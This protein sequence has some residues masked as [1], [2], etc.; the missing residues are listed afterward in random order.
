MLEWMHDE[1][2]TNN[3]Q[4]KFMNITLTDCEAFIRSSWEDKD[5]LHMAAADDNDIYMGTV[6]LKNIDP[7]AKT[8]EFAIA[9]RRCALGTGISAYAMQEIL[10]HGLEVLGLEQIYW[11][12]SLENTRAVRFYD[13]HRYPRVAPAMLK[14]P[15]ASP[16][17]ALP[18][19]I[20]YAVTQ[21]QFND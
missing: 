3:L 18:N 20:F 19:M 16:V 15:A 17:C 5:N 12:V 14:L 1:D 10:R 4:A 8:A 6:S 2:L 7:T 13:K 11:Y 9:F 21:A